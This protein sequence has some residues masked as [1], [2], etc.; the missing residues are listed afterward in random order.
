MWYTVIT[1]NLAGAMLTHGGFSIMGLFNLIFG[2]YSEREIKKITPIVD[3]IESL[4]DAF[5]T[6]TDEEMKEYTDK[7][8]SL[9]VFHLS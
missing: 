8:K 5:K 7:L 6:L 9:P 3:K 4:A 1:D 2:S